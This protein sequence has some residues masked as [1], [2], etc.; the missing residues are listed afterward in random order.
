MAFGNSGFHPSYVED[1][2]YDLMNEPEFLCG[3]DIYT[4]SLFGVICD[5]IKQD[6]PGV[7]WEAH[8]HSTWIPGVYRM[9]FAWVEDGHVHL[10]GWNYEEKELDW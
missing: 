4:D 2:I 10:I 3:F 8:V 5:M 9:S 6:F 7:E 1:R